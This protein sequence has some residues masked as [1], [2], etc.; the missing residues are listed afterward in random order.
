M[1]IDDTTITSED[2]KVD[3]LNRQWF[4]EAKVFPYEKD[5]M[6]SLASRMVAEFTK[7]HT[8]IASAIREIATVAH[9]LQKEDYTTLL[10]SF[11]K[12]FK[13]SP[14]HREELLQGLVHVVQSASP[15]FLQS[16]DLVRILSSISTRLQSTD[17]ESSLYLYHLTLAVSRILS[18]MA[19]HDFKVLDREAL[20]DPLSNILSELRGRSDPYLMYQA[21]Y[22]FQALQHTPGD[23]TNLQTFLRYSTGMVD[24]L[25]KVSGLVQLNF[26][27][28]MEGLKEIQEVVE[29]TAGTLKSAFEGVMV[30][31]ENGGGIIDS[32]KQ[33]LGLKRRWYQAILGATKFIREGQFMDLKNLI[34]E[35]PCRHEPL[36]QMGICQLLGEI[37]DDDAWDVATRK[38]A[39]DFIEE[40]S[41]RDQDWGQDESVKRGTWEIVSRISK[42][43]EQSIRDH[44]SVLERKLREEGYFVYLSLS[45]LRSH[46]APPSTFDLLNRVQNFPDIE[47]DLHNMAK[48]QMKFHLEKH[49]PV[50]IPPQAKASLQAE[51]NDHFPLMKEVTTFVKGGRKVFLLLGDSGAGK[52]TFNHMLAYEIWSSYRVRGCIPLFV[53][54]P[55]VSQSD[56][57][58]I[59]YRLE[60]F[61]MSGPQIKELMEQEREFIL[62]CDGYDERQLNTNLHTDNN[63]NQPGSWRAKL[64]ISCR[65]QYLKK[66]Y[67]YDF[68]PETD[69]SSHRASAN[70]VFQEAVIVPFTKEQVEHYVK[71][72]VGLPDE[73]LDLRDRPNW[74]ADE[75]ME[76][77]D[78]IPDLMDLVGNPFLLTVSLRVLH[79]VIGGNQNLTKVRVT[80]I[81][82]YDIFID[83]WILRKEK[84]L[85]DN[86]TSLS[87]KECREL[88]KLMDDDILLMHAIE[89][90]KQLATSIFEKQP[91]N[92]NIKYSEFSDN[93]TW[94]GKYFSNDN[95]KNS[96]LRKVSPIEGRG[97]QFRLLHPSLLEYFYSRKF[98]DP[99][100]TPKE[101]GNGSD[102]D[103]D[104]GNDDAP[105]FQ[106][107]RDSLKT[108]PLTKK[109]IVGEPLVV[110]FLAERAR[111]EPRFQQQLLVMMDTMET[112]IE[113]VQGAKNAVAIL[114][115]AGIRFNGVDLGTIRPRRMD[116]V[117]LTKQQQWKQL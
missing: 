26:T 23:E 83:Q 70:E 110:E 18:V 48:T 24:G 84:R 104:S 99:V 75:Y 3:D 96:I 30:L 9:V 74:T 108:H 6:V 58:L 49:H 32:I 66:K 41:L 67:L 56:K 51:N 88:I 81:K 36:F 87:V 68:L 101:D 109:D 97:T 98:F 72:F 114:V 71:E 20:R 37:A 45:P 52:T 44:A 35:A 34:I 39:I 77:L 54:L 42:V 76:K 53:D 2:R 12:E 117:P 59:T 8:H 47:K 19:D 25:I 5:F 106:A 92:H 112:D 111:T 113:S 57:D 61:K 21:C 80:R 85:Y 15:G 79:Q 33:G 65:S 103:S 31:V 116:S 93:T 17:P 7:N 107:L 78:A 29:K 95:P 62:I 86:R 60:R 14:T 40:L 4:K 27:G 64:I 1:E 100:E 115:E 89:F 28:F 82:L 50:Y 22:A 94:K 10:T 55:K 43:Q 13:E 11:I 16:D 102:S 69:G 91:G 90:M 105:S 63:L 46:L 38:H 73:V